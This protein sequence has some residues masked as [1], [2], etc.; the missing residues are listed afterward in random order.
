MVLSVANC[1]N[2]QAISQV[3]TIL[4]RPVIPSPFYIAQ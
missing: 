4:L 3:A 1:A 2:A